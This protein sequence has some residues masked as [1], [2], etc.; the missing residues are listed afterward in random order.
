MNEIAPYAIPL[1]V[2]ALA[3]FLST[4]LVFRLDSLPRATFRASVGV[5]S[6][7]AAG[8]LYAVARTSIITTPASAYIAFGAALAVWGWHELSFLTGSLTGPNRLPEA[9]GMR[10]WRRFRSAARTLIHHEIAL[11]LTLA[12]L[13][14][15][16]WRAPNQTA[17]ATFALLFIMR[18]ST[19]LNIFVG[20]PNPASDLLPGHLAYLKTYFRRR[21]SGVMM[22]GSLVMSGAVAFWF[23]EHAWAAPA[24][25]GALVSHSLLFALTTLAIVEHLFLALP[26][27]DASL[28][29]WAVPAPLRLQPKTTVVPSGT[30][31]KYL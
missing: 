15:L 16:T 10:G 1:G 8:A 13:V 21:A 24:G 27:R 26:V 31:T 6:V 12:L 25:S 20:V 23:A 7:V 11:A 28:W 29:A 19:K 30:A 18:L 17:T 22:A 2:A 14:A 5:A 3:W 4:G 9:A